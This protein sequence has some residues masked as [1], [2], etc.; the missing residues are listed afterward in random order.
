[1]SALRAG[2][3]A[4]DVRAPN[5]RASRWNRGRPAIHLESVAERLPHGAALAWARRDT[6][7]ARARLERIYG[8]VPACVFFYQR[9]P[10]GPVSVTHGLRIV[11]RVAELYRG[12]ER[13]VLVRAVVPGAAALQAWFERRDGSVMSTRLFGA[14]HAY[15]YGLTG[16]MRAATVQALRESDHGLRDVERFYAR[17]MSVTEIAFLAGVERESMRRTVDRM[18]ALGFDLPHRNTYARR[19]ASA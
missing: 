1:M 5:A 9:E 12:D 10:D 4:R 19:V 2:C 15:A 3:P 7:A 14:I 6:Q 13:P 11:G 18:R 17:G 16:D 8:R